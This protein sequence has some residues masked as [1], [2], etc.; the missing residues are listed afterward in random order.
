[1]LHFIHLLLQLLNL[2][3]ELLLIVDEACS[4]S[5][6]L[7]QLLRVV[8]EGL[9]EVPLEAGPLLMRLLGFVL[10]RFVDLIGAVELPQQQSLLVDL[11]LSICD[12]LVF[13]TDD[14]PFV[15]KLL[16]LLLK[17]LVEIPVLILQQLVELLILHLVFVQALG[18]GLQVYPQLVST[19]VVRVQFL[20]QHDDLLIQVRDRA[21]LCLQS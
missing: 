11:S 14:V 15:P 5:G 4:R 8:L 2:G 6:F 10:Q 19:R 9:L 16:F 18:C 13:L 17:H 21:K 20:S 12:R 1:L 7:I 3:L